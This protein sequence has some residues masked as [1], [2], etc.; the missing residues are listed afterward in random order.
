MVDVLLAVPEFVELEG[1]AVVVDPPEATLVAETLA[2]LAT[3][4]VESVEV[5]DRIEYSD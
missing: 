1:G 5:C 2:T 3:L 4:A